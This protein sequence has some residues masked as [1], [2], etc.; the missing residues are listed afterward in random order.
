MERS[1]R[2]EENENKGDV[3]VD[4][5]LS[6]NSQTAQTTDPTVEAQLAQYATD[7]QELY[8]GRK[9]LERTAADTQQQF[10]L[11]SHEVAA[12]NKFL[13]GRLGEMFQM[14]AEFETLLDGLESVV[15]SIQP[16]M[17]RT[18]I[19]AWVEHAKQVLEKIRGQRI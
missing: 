16:A 4:E 1:Q 19:R 3:D 11:R 6:R 12:L 14:E 13:Q 5:Q 8:K 15:E 10:L 17:L 2:N 7:L 9:D 18:T